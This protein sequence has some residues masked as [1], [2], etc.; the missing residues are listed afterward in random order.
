[1]LAGDAAE[2]GVKTA[3]MSVAHETSEENPYSAEEEAAIEESLRG[4]GYVE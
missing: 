1:M 2:R 4:L 3:G